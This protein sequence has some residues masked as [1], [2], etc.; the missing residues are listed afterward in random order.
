MKR[1]LTACVVTALLSGLAWVWVA[2]ATAA[3]EDHPISADPT[4]SQQSLATSDSIAYAARV[5]SGNK[6]GLTITNYGFIGSNFSSAAPSFEYPLGSNHMH[7]VRGG[8]W[9]GAI[10]ADENGAFVGVTIAAQDGSAGSSSAGT[11]EFTPA[12]TYIAA[13]STL[14]NNR[15]YDPEAISELDFISSYSDR[16]AIP[17]RKHRP[18]G[19]IVNQYQFEWSF[20]DYAHFV[21]FHWVIHNDGPPLRDVWF[22]LYN[23]LASGDFTGQAQLPPSGFF[24][25]KWMTWN[26]SLNM[27]TEQYCVS[28]PF[29]TG[30]NNRNVPQIA[31]VKL[32]GCI[33]GDIHDTTDKRVTFASWSYAPG[34][35][36]RDVDSLKYQI[37][38]TGKKVSLV[39]MPD[40][41]APSSGDPVELIAVGPFNTI[42]PGDS[43]SVDFAYI[44]GLTQQELA[45]RAVV[46]QRA[47]DLHYIVPTPPPSPKLKV[48]ARSNAI[49][50]YWED[51]PESVMDP[52]S[53]IGK[54]FEG[55][56]VY[57]GEDRDSLS[58]LG[59][60]DLATAPHDTTGFNTGLGAIRLANPVMLDGVPY[61][62]KFTIDHLRDGF[63]YFVAVNS[64]DTG[65]PNIESLE[66]GFAQ[67]EVMT[68]TGPAPGEHGGGVSVFPNPY[69][70]EA[71]WDRGAQARDHYLWFTNLP[72]QCT[73]QI[74]TLAGDLIFTTEFDGSSYDGSNARGIFTPGTG[75]HSVLSGTTFGWDMITRQG[76]ACATGLY[77]WA[78]KDKKTGARQ[79]G[80]VLIVKSDR[81]SF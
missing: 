54:D 67:N 58:L 20:S 66:S 77:L 29:P 27:V 46:A 34:S 64:F 72:T 61:Y 24:S 12:G 79:S 59:Q 5:M 37:M 31:A 74:F 2:A 40:S 53:P 28:Q 15:Y 1:L 23:E 45:H 49:D 68:V 69:R 60:F 10:S 71:S 73:L 22:G 16:P 39:P 6:V 43:I 51:S 21:I 30:C 65:D 35:P 7:L 57:I 36:A 62:Y 47:Y 42:N 19:V 44:G 17:L 81:E 38:S 25:K 52:T 48:I 75:I 33:P 55:Y 4:R 13:R 14:I 18:L 11:G 78:V 80:K 41:L 50:C 70:V 9:I 8:P 56:R 32:L 26:D 63:K 3:S 76:Q